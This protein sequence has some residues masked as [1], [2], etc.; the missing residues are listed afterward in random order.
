M[1]VVVARCISLCCG[2]VR[3]CCCSLLQYKRTRNFPLARAAAVLLMLLLL[4]LLMLLLLHTGTRG[5]GFCWKGVWDFHCHETQLQRA[6][7]RELRK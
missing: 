2:T 1:W 7:K 6:S 4:L 3:A 5:L